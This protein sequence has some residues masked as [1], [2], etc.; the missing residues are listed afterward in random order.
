M[1]ISFLFSFECNKAY[2]HTKTCAEMFM[3]AL[4]VITKAGNK[5]PFANDWIN[6]L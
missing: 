3:A 5:C 2:I 6:K 1:G 4:F